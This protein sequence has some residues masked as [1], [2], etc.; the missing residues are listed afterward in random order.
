[1]G[2]TGRENKSRAFIQ[3]ELPV[4]KQRAYPGGSY[5]IPPSLGT[6]TTKRYENTSSF[7]S[8]QFYFN[9]PSVVF[10]TTELVQRL[11]SS[12][13]FNRPSS[14]RENK[15]SKPFLT[16]GFTSELG[17]LNFT[18][19]SGMEVRTF[20]FPLCL[21]YASMELYGLGTVS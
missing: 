13:K 18:G 1:M 19:P 6:F 7:Q 5:S 12:L 14:I 2:K 10:P 9:H 3:K 15:K 16:G 8:R 21:L 17:R 20:L 11:E 4:G